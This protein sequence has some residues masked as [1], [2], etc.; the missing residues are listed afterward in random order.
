MKFEK[1]LSLF[2]PSMAQTAHFM[3]EME[4]H[5]R[6]PVANLDGSVGLI[7]NSHAMQ[8]TAG[9]VECKTNVKGVGDL[10]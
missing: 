5:K 3:K 9:K 6:E 1:D 10:L 2:S 8:F 4:I 7:L